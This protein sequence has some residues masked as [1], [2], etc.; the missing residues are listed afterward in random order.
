MVAVSSW[1]DNFPGACVKLAV[2]PYREGNER[3]LAIVLPTPELPSDFIPFPAQRHPA[4]PG[5]GSAAGWCV[6]FRQFEAASHRGGHTS[7]PRLSLPK[8]G[9]F[10]VRRYRFI[11]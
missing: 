3:R 7:L 9:A 11:R 6:V 8:A 5:F 10:S 4:Q 1:P 2:A